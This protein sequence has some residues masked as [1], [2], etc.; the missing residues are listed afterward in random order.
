MNENYGLI[1]PRE[2]KTKKE[3]AMHVL[4]SSLL[5]SDIV[6]EKHDWQPFSKDLEY[7]ALFGETNSCTVQAT[8]NAKQLYDNKDGGD[9]QNSKKY[10]A[11]LAVLLNVLNPKFGADPHRLLEL[12][13]LYTGFI[14]EGKLPNEAP[15]Y[16]V[17]T[18]LLQSLRDEDGQ[19][20]LN[21][22]KFNHGW[23]WV[24]QP[25][26]AKKPGIIHDALGMGPVAV[27]GKAWYTNEKGLY[28]KPDF[29]VD[30]HFFVILAVEEDHYVA[31]DSYPP[32]IKKLDLSFDFTIAKVIYVRP[33]YM[34][35]KNLGFGTR[36][37]EMPKLQEALTKELGYSIPHAVTD[38]FGSE[39]KDALYRFQTSQGIVDDGTHFGPR[40][41]YAINKKLNPSYGGFLEGLN[42]FVA[43]LTAKG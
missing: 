39:T 5:P 10:I 8:V 24:D 21:F 29:S 14:A 33:Q 30:N 27:S 34:F 26:V 12:V 4:G 2:I 18:D 28:Y 37:R 36:N 16:G 43:S 25:A 19:F 32:Y 23:L 41:R 9:S 3:G 13:R 17:D 40:T 38:Y 22:N 20:W 7:Q 35:T 15:F 11:N 1:L 6:N 42:T 31:L